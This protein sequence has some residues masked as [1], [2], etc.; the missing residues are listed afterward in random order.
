MAA[1]GMAGIPAGPRGDG[2]ADMAVMPERDRTA[3][4]GT[5][6]AMPSLLLCLEKPLHLSMG[7]GWTH[8]WLPLF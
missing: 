3:A 2:A 1:K 5:V 8:I 6:D 4:Q 7:L